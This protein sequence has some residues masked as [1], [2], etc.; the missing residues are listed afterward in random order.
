MNHQKGLVWVRS[1]TRKHEE[2]TPLTPKD[3]HTLITRGH[4]IH[5]ESSSQRIFTDDEY[6]AAD[7][8]I[9]R[10]GSWTNAP[11]H[12]NVLGIKELPAEEFPIANRHIYFAHAYRGQPGAA[13][14]LARFAR[15]QGSILDIEYLRNEKW[16]ISLIEPR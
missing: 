16:K 13:A 10:P 7:C 3:A 2:R 4:A 12:A 1:E 8:I 9:E 11:P 5:V 15:G 6:A 14:L